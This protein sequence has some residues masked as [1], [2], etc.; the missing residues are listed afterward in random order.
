M[1]ID[2]VYDN[3][4]GS[5]VEVL[6]FDL[7]ELAAVHGVGLFCGKG[8]QI[9]KIRARADLLV[10]CKA[11]RD[12]AMRNLRVR[13]Q[14]RAGGNNLGDPGL[15]IRAEQRG[16]V[17]DDQI[18]ADIVAE[19]REARG[20]QDLS[21]CQHQILARVADDR[22]TDVFAA[23]IGR[24]VHVCNEP[25]G[26][27]VFVSCACGQESVDVAVFV[28]AGVRNADLVQLFDKKFAED[29]LPLCGGRRRALFFRGGFK[30]NI[31]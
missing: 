25:D 13:K 31:V 24:C 16:A 5:S 1:D 20:G 19:R 7:A 4:R 27:I 30:G 6:V 17:G 29:A 21:V 11:D 18:L 3:M 28:D 8:F 22:G 10:R 15:V 14:V 26:G 23:D 9:Q 12:G 2:A